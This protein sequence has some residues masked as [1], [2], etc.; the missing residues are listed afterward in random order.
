MIRYL[1]D[2]EYVTDGSPF[3]RMPRRPRREVHLI[4][5]CE[6]GPSRYV[7]TRSWDE[8]NSYANRA[9]RVPPYEQYRY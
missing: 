8:K 4:P 1:D 7:D 6:C 2:G 9:W 3:D 5:K